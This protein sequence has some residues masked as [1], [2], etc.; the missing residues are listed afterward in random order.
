MHGRGQ[1][2]GL[3]SATAVLAAAI[4]FASRTETSQQSQERTVSFAKDVRP[5]MQK[6]CAGCHTGKN[7]PANVD[8]LK[9]KTD[10]DVQKDDVTWERIARAIRSGHMPPEGSPQPTQEQ[11][12]F[13]VSAIESIISGNCTLRDPGRVTIR[14]LNKAEYVN[15]IRDLMGVNFRGAE[16]FPSDDVGYG[17]DNIGDVLTLS[18][19]HLE[20][21]LDAAETIVAEAIALPGAKT[22]RI[23]ASFLPAAQGTNPTNEGDRSFF[24]NAVINLD[25]DFKLAGAYRIR[26]HAFGQ[27]AGPEACRMRISVGSNGQDFTVSAI[28][29]KPADYEF[30]V[31]VAAGRRR[32][33]I[34][35][36]NDFY[37]P[38]NP[39]PRQRDRNLIVRHVEIIGPFGDKVALP[40]STTRWIPQQPAPG[41]EREFAKRYLTAFASRAFRRPVESEELDG[42]LRVFDVA[43]KFKEP[44]N[45]SMQVAMTAVLVSPQ[46]LFR[47]ELDP[48]PNDAKASREL[49][50]W[51]LASRLS[52]FLWSS[53]P[54]EELVQLA[55][56]KRLTDPKTLEAQV[57]RMLKDPKAKALGDNFAAQWL[58]LRKLADFRPDPRSYT[59]FSPTIRSAML[60]ESLMFFNDIVAHDR[61]ILEFLESR[62][63]FVNNALA[64]Y[65]DI[66]GVQSNE[67]RRVELPNNTRGGLLGQGSIL[68]LT[69]NPT[70]TSPT[71]RGKWVLEQILGTP[72][73]PPPPGADV[74]A[75]AKP[76]TAL[77]TL[78]QQMDAHR[79]KPDCMS[80]HSRMDPLGFGL[81]NYDAVGRWRF[82]DTDET[83]IDSTGV[84]PDGTKFSGPAELRQ[85]LLSRK[86]QFAHALSEKLMIY[87]LGRGVTLRDDCSIDEVTA[88]VKQENFRISA[89]IKGIVL[90]EPFR[91]RRGDGGEGR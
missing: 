37:D 16:G 19:L 56:T 80:C 4:G 60:T 58:Q 27:Q 50:G 6:W 20:K 41:Q 89:I 1:A 51:E 45:R 33:G 76:G 30:P 57:D 2:I 91:M 70:R 28:A 69:S 13:L 15:T 53:L 66:P 34:A 63:T 75:P 73:P 38:D 48:K 84:L 26:V 7:P 3:L 87:A 49:N 42:L 65:Y 67:F 85:V 54:D 11:R 52:Y 62:H 79:Q 77:K 10:A 71:K 43:H 32:I 68:T 90:S 82:R 9:A 29:E 40:P 88:R 78:R 72:P 5:Q 21:Y 12:T 86:D 14:R 31:E 36:T 59:S 8:P 61:S 23:E 81:E 83:E 44:F 18:P 39:N 74:L 64:A 47:A 55:Q 17:F 35:F 22:T 25:H 24:T 46:F